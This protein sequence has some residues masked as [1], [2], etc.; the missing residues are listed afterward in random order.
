VK[1]FVYNPHLFH[2]CW[3]GNQRLA[4]FF[5]FILSIRASWSKWYFRCA[6]TAFF[7]WGLACFASRPICYATSV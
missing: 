2:P 3:P 7:S 4:Y 1:H 6:S 5:T